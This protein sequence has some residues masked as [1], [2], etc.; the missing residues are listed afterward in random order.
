VIV[1]QSLLA[2]TPF[3][4]MIKN[5]VDETAVEGTADTHYTIPNFHVS[6][7]H[8]VVN[9]P[10]LWWRSVGHTHN[11]FVMETLI[12]ELATRAKADP[13]TYRLNL[14]SPDAK[15]LRACL[16]LLEEK[17]SPW[18]NRVSPDH[19]VGVACHES[20][21]T[22]V[23]CAVEV[24][25]Q[26]G[27]PRVHRAT[28]AVDPGFAVNPLTIE[29]QMQGGVSFGITQLMPLGA[30][31]LKDGRVE[32][33]NWDGYT[34]PYMKDAPVVADVHIVP[35]SEKPSGCGEPP[36]PVISPAIV[37]A[38]SRLTGKRYRKLPLTEI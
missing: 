36:V 6:A 29:S 3:A 28:I 37:N 34:P 22:G 38:V 35:S 5:G 32:Q 33:R 10:V 27:R 21:G 17:T 20:F 15:K 11:A 14:L 1:G 19:A 4:S 7:H 30:I 8:P 31:T 26:D 2:G 23:A 18:R 12:D 24:S 16:T 25:I 9:V 13:I